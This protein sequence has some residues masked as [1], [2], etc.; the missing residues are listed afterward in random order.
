MSISPIERVFLLMDQQSTTIAPRPRRAC[1]KCF[2]VKEKC[3]LSGDR[4]ICDRCFRLNNFCETKRS[5]GKVGRKPRPKAPTTITFYQQSSSS[6]EDTTTFSVPQILSMF[7]DLTQPRNTFLY[8]VLDKTTSFNT[9][10]MGPTVHV[11]LKQA[12]LTRLDPTPSLLNDGYL[13]SGGCII[14][15]EGLEIPELTHDANFARARSSPFA[16]AILTWSSLF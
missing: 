10:L 14:L 3:I 7:V 6:Q 2:S 9:F 5:R 12:I 15:N 13:A 1:D 8:I 16:N 4:D 11:P